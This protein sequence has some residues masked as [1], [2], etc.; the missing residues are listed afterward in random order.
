MENL[1]QELSSRTA[2]LA[3]RG[4]E[5]VVR[6]EGRRASATGTV[7]SA[8][9]VVVLAHHSL[10]WDEEVEVGL[11][12]GETVPGEVA[13][14]DPSTD[15][16][17]VRARTSGLVAPD[18]AE[19]DGLALG[20]LVLGVSRPGRSARSALAMLSRVAGEW[21]A[22]H[23]G[24]IDRYLE[25]SLPLAPGLSGSVVMDV[26]GRALG[27]ATAGLARGA[28]IAVPTPTLRRVVKGL[29]AHGHV[30][31]GYLGIATVPVRL[32]GPAAQAAGGEG[33]L[34]ITGVEPESPAARGGLLLG[35]VLV[36]IAGTAVAEYGDLLPVLEEERIGDTVPVRVLRAGEARD[37]TVAVGA[38]ERRK[39]AR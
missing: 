21:R 38:R 26:S 20:Q 5:S 36:S 33:A 15:L 11:P 39:G 1:L 10:E 37:L 17:I 9:G 29:L 27:I 4:A 19:P 28:A 34:L 24:R 31:R 2:A 14:R 35:D 13:G 30:R 16:A 12:S 3:A 32:S 8:D 7:W 6:V 25:T 23:G 22:P 18:W